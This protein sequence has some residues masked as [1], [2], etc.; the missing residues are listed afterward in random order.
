MQRRKRAGMGVLLGMIA[1]GLAQ[2]D[3]PP[4]GGAPADA[5][6]LNGYVYTVDG[7]DSVRQ[8]LAVRGGRIAYVGTDAGAKALAGPATQVVDLHG[9][10]VMPGL[11]DGHMHPLDGGLTLIQC[12]LNYERLTVPQFQARIQ[13]CLDK[14]R[15][16]E[17][18]QWLE[19]VNWFQQDMLPAG[20]TV[21]HE[22]LDALKTHRPIAVMS[23]FG[24]SVLANARALQLGHVD[25]ST[26][27]PV[28]GK[29]Q[30]DAGGQPSGILEDAAYDKVM[31]LIPPPT[32][33]QD[34]AAAR[35]AL[36]ALRK[37][38]VTTFLDALAENADLESFT[39]VQRGGGLT[40]RAHF[41]VP[42]RPAADLDPQ[43]AVAA[44][45]ATA[46]HFDQGP[47]Q[48][49]PSIIVR[50]AKLFMDGVITAPA[51]TGAMLEPYLEN[52][53]TAAQPHWVP[54][55]DRGPPVYFPADKLSAI[56]IGLAHDGIEPHMHADGDRAVHEALNAVAAMRKQF[57]ESAIRAAIAHDEIVSPADFPRYAQLGTVPVLSFQWEKRAPDTVEGA[58]D[59]LGPARYKYME[60]AGYLAAAG[61][62]I[63]YGSDWPVDRLDEWF[64]LKV[65]VTR[66]NDPAAGP[67]YAGRLSTDTG[68]TLPAVLRAITANA[69]YELHSENEVGS[70]ETGKFA[71]FIVL[72]RN[73]FKIP[74]Q[75][76]AAVEVLLT[77]VGGK[78]V[79]RGP[80]FEAGG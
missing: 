64:A 11:I 79:Y 2:A 8:A 66:E 46:T 33:E 17:P 65:G 67:K 13:A 56:L 61:A 38:G 22:T 74:P 49:A 51:F 40:A 28:G 77:V 27:D 1:A 41:A 6:Y 36:E 9:R 37:Q 16:G 48:P 30:H 47:E 72:D 7:K 53:G 59:Y 63:A 80:G 50:N 19:V 78:A 23:S 3:A 12:N 31:K 29:I 24:H 5:V 10:M 73:L 14:T 32:P 25:R 42:I 34:V 26:P 21:S 76:I 43:K 45:K 18:G 44:V 35:A 60:P 54:G 39:R 58:Q 57:P 15:A 55:K 68:L 70:L 20:V 4:P 75:Q 69:A 52:Q 71:D 62:R